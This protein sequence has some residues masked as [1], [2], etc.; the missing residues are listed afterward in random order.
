MVRKYKRTLSNTRNGKNYKPYFAYSNENLQRA[1]EDVRAKKLTLLEAE[2]KYLV[3]KSTIA[4][5]VSRQNKND[6]PGRPN[7]FSQEEETVF[8]EHLNLVA[9]WGYPFDLLDLRLMVKAYLDKLGLQEK[10]LKNNLPGPDWATNFIKRHKH[11]ISNRLSSNISTKRASLSPPII[12]QFFE[13]AR[14]LLE[15]TDPSLNT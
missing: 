2:K 5:R 9:S 7:L 8:L 6:R 11:L 3:P 15:N 1:V 10:R 14:D 12:E 13:N 4:R